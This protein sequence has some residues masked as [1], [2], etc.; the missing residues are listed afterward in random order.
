MTYPWPF[1]K[2]TDL[3][4]SQIKAGVKWEE[5]EAKL[6]KEM[7]LKVVEHENAV[8]IHLLHTKY[9]KKVEFELIVP[10]YCNMKGKNS[11]FT[12]NSLFSI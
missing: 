4:L 5:N 7:P 11:H 1:L 10:F 2:I 9:E 6:L 8:N 12:R 3:Q